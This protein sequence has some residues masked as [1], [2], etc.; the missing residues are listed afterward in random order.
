[1]KPRLYFGHPVNT[2]GTELETKLLEIII[3]AFP[4]WTIENPSEQKHRDGYLKVKN[5]TGNGM[6][7]F[8]EQ[9]LPKCDGGVF[10]TF[11]DNRWGAG[12]FN[13]AKTLM[14]KGKPAWQ[15]TPDGRVTQLTSMNS[16]VPLSVSET[17]QRVYGQN[18]STKPY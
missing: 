4:C 18:G 14:E 7:Y 1:M 17:R 15:I 5:K 11:R 13:E 2:Y 10:L 12:I 9:V 3:A 16:I 6:P 8:T